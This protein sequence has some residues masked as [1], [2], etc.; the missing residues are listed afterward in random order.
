MMQDARSTFG[1][2]TDHAVRRSGII[3]AALPLLDRGPDAIAFAAAK[4]ASMPPPMA[5]HILRVPVGY[6]ASANRKT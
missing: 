5:D 2:G 3:N 1:P 6:A 4:L